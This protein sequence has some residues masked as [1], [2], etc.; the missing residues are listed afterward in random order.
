MKDNIININKDTL[1]KKKYYDF[2]MKDNIIYINKYA[3]IKKKW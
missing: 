1:I 3:L 2:S